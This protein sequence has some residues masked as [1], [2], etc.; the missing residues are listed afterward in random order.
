MENRM[1]KKEFEKPKKVVFEK[2]T[3]KE[4]ETVRGGE[5][6]DLYKPR[7]RQCVKP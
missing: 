7:I 2:L 6:N 5:E 1:K 4:T 3:V